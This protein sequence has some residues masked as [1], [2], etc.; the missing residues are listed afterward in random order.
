M[1]AFVSADT[2]SAPSLQRTC[3]ALYTHIPQVSWTGE[4]RGGKGRSR[5]RIRPNPS[6]ASSI[7]RRTT[8]GGRINLLP[9]R[10][11]RTAVDRL[12]YGCKGLSPNGVSVSLH[13]TPL[14]GRPPPPCPDRDACRV[15]RSGARETHP[16]PCRP[17][18]SLGLTPTGWRGTPA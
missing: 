7:N 3:L 6:M 5:R 1:T 2:I 17:L 10:P 4:D 8:H 11:N 12:A 15:F 18:K 16:F 13:Q 9:R 14:S